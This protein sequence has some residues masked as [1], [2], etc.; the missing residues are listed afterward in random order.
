MI[1]VGSYSCSLVES[2]LP[3]SKTN[4]SCGRL[5]VLLRL[6]D[7][8]DERGAAAGLD[9]LLRRLPGIIQL[10]VPPWILIGRVEDGT[11]EERVRRHAIGSICVSFWSRGQMKGDAGRLA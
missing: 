10:P 2:P 6:R 1:E 11:I 9:D 4:V 8:R 3:P 5:L 7:G